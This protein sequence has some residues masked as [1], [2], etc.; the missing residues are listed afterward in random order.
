MKEKDLIIGLLNAI[1]YIEELQ[2]DG[3]DYI[4]MDI[5]G[6]GLR[7]EDLVDRLEELE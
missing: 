3:V 7:R 1:D 6:L 5:L 2:G 4:T